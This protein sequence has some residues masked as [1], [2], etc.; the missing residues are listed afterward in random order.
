MSDASNVIATV[1]V[2]GDEEHGFFFS[3]GDRDPV[4]PFETEEIATEKALEFLQAAMTRLVE[5]TLNGE[6]K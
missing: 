5:Q 2:E 3:L 4:G 6:L 1:N